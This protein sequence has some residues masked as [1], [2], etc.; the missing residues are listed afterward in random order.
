MTAGNWKRTIE[1]LYDKRCAIVGGHLDGLTV[2]E[3]ETYDVI[4]WCN[5]HWLKMTA[6]PIHGLFHCCGP[7]CPAAAMLQHRELEKLLFFAG[8][9]WSSESSAFYTH[10]V[11]HDIPRFFFG[12]DPKC[13]WIWD[14]PDYLCE[15]HGSATP[16]TGLMAANFLHHM[17]IKS[18]ALLGQSLYSGE[19]LS[20]GTAAHNPAGQARVFARLLKQDKRFT[21]CPALAEA[22]SAAG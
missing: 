3:L 10:C 4:V 6:A 1:A 19:A 15:L 5:N 9:S 20:P 18:C 2:T 7:R 11:R 22:I 16:L 17:P 13:D 8:P 14:D 12:D 21:A